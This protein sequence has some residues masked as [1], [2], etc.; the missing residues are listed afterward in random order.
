MQGGY[1]LRA[2][3]IQDVR[4]LDESHQVLSAADLYKP[5]VC[6]S[7]KIKIIPAGTRGCDPGAVRQTANLHNFGRILQEKMLRPHQAMSRSPM[8]TVWAHAQPNTA[9]I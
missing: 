1:I 5:I 2:I 9:G 4:E 6:H 8:T 7:C 3:L